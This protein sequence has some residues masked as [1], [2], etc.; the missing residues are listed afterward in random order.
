[1]QIILNTSKVIKFLSI[2]AIAL[3]FIHINILIIY[4]IVDDPDKFDFVRMFDLDMERNIPT[5]FSS[6]YTI[7]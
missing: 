2:V 7:H 4:F 1:M 5:L 6:G 3:I